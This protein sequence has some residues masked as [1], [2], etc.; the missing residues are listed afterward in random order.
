MFDYI[1]FTRFAPDAPDE[2]QIAP[3]ELLQGGFI[4]YTRNVIASKCK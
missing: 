3:I 4:G 2:I 1:G